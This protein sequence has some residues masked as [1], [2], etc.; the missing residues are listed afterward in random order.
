MTE[1]RKSREEIIAENPIVGFLE[2]R[3]SVFKRAGREMTCLCPLHEDSSPSFRVDPEKGA[4]F[5]DPCGIGGSIIDLVMR[6]DGLQ[7]GPA[8]AKLCGTVEQASPRRDDHRAPGKIVKTYDYHDEHGRLV[9]QVARMEPKTFRQRHKNEK[10]DWVWGMEGIR[11]VPYNLPAVMASQEPVWIVEGEKD[12]DTLNGTGG[13]ATTNPMGAGKWLDAYNE[14]FRGKNVILCGDNDEPGRKHVE[15]LTAALGE[16]ARSVRIVVIPEPHKDISDLLSLPGGL[17][18]LESIC[19]AAPV[20]SGGIM[21]PI[22]SIGEM[23]QRYAEYCTQSFARALPLSSVLP[24]LHRL[25]RLVPGELMVIIADTGVGKTFLLQNIAI[26]ARPLPVLIFEMELPE[27][28]MFERFASMA[29]GMAASDVED[30]YCQRRDVDWRATGK[31]DNIHVCPRSRM[32]TK[33]I[34]RFIRASEL[35]TG[36]KPAVVMIDYIG[37]IR[38]SGKR[39]ERISD[40]CEELKVIA[41][42]TQTIIIATSQIARKESEDPEIFLH[43]GK[44]S[45]SIENS[46]GVVLGAWRD[47]AVSDRIWLKVCKS[48]K[49]G[50]G[51]RISCRL[52][53]SL[54]IE[55]E[56]TITR[57]EAASKN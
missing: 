44:E 32:E 56:I 14:F 6:L 47:T 29:M 31:L 38:G 12:A 53:Q 21:L 5:C 41:K 34:E 2:R 25:R 26:A 27:T 50:A 20:V 43:D 3:G 39:Y 15:R 37:L 28:L 16:V 8:I 51:T 35:K 18:S 36:E 30:R 42:E 54:V 52:N 13:V 33:D 45:G 46:A 22:L 23:E 7:I 10:G 55:E 57:Q 17:Q 24:S 1:T 19:R 49:G 11:R 48:T 9:F 4:W 40:A